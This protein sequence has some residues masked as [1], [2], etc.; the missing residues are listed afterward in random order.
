[1][2]PH[3][4]EYAVATPSRKTFWSTVIVIMVLIVGLVTFLFSAPSDFVP[5]TMISVMSGDSIKQIAQEL[6]EAKIIRSSTFFNLAIQISDNPIVAVGDYLFE[7]P[8]GVLTVASRLTSSQYGLPITQ[9]TLTEGMTASEMA[10]KLT[11]LFPKFDS[12]LFLKLAVPFEGRLFPDTYVFNQN[13]T[14]EDIFKK[15]RS[16]FDKKIAAIQTEIDTSPYTEEQ[17]IIMA[18]IVEKEATRDS[19]E[20]VANILWNR[21]EIGMALQVDA[22]FVYAIGKSTAE[23]TKADLEKD[24]PYNTY[25]NLGLTPTAISNPGIDAIL[26]AAHPQPT[27]NLYF[28]TGRDGKMYYAQSF[29]GHKRNR[30][31]YLD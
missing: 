30:A 16:T 20:E 17:I 23:L 12:L 18:S 3:E 28:L 25:K 2:P 21:F 31:L 11:T 5:G 1:M 7:K 15:L 22:S 13:A 19:R 9:V 6:K 14:A 4:L 26:A 8:Q 29:E 27:K 24:G 10:Q